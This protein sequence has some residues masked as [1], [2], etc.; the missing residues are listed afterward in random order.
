MR[1]CNRKRALNSELI[2]RLNATQS[3]VDVLKK[4]VPQIRTGMDWLWSAP[5]CQRS[6]LHSVEVWPSVF[7]ATAS[8]LFIQQNQCGVTLVNLCWLLLW[9][10]EVEGETEERAQSVSFRGLFHV[11]YLY[12]YIKI[13]AAVVSSKCWVLFVFAAFTD[14][15]FSLL[16]HRIAESRLQKVYS[17]QALKRDKPPVTI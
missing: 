10:R 9:Q 8:C 7:T 13:S 16:C 1:R 6:A 14:T 2:F 4:E 17:T 11:F 12:R 5:A 15:M 3:C